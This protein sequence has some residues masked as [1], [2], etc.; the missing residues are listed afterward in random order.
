V[1]G[2]LVQVFSGKY[3]PEHQ[4]VYLELP[5]M[6]KPPMIVPERLAVPCISESCLPSCFID[7]VDIIVSELVLHGFI[8]CLNTVGY[9]GDFWGDN[10]FSTIHQ[11]ERR[12]SRGPA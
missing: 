11:E 6:H 10:S 9:H 1:R 12:L 8:V 5:T 4:I 2:E 7:Q 3:A